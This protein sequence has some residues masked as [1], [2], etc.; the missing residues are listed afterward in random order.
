MSVK[1]ERSSTSCSFR[2]RKGTA[3]TTVRQLN[4]TTQ[5]RQLLQ[6]C[7]EWRDWTEDDIDFLKKIADKIAVEMEGLIVL[8]AANLQT[9]IG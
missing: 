7:D 1:N 9:S 3:K 6:Q 2:K 8:R 4:I 5:D